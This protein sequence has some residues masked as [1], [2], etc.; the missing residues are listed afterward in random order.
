MIPYLKSMTQLKSFMFECKDNDIFYYC[1]TKYKVI[2]KTNWEKINLKPF[3][4]HLC[5]TSITLLLTTS[6]VETMETKIAVC[7]ILPFGNRYVA[8][9]RKDHDSFGFIGGKVD[10][11]ESLNDALI[12]E[13]REETGF[14]VEIDY[15]YPPF[16]EEDNDFLVLCYKLKLKTKHGKL[17]EGEEPFLYLLSKEQLLTHSLF[18]DYNK[19]AFQWFSMI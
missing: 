9:K 19:K 8:V 10:E 13:T 6:I 18:S 14:E 1:D 3:T 4:Q 17:K 5:P 12:R 2:G 15:S 7:G 16:V 11:G